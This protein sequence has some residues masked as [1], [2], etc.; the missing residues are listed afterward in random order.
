MQIFKVI[1]E[2]T[3]TNSIS[4]G[5]VTMQKYKGYFLSE[6]G[7]LISFFIKDNF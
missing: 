2:E 7:Q 5:M 6:L 4:E 3:V 1:R